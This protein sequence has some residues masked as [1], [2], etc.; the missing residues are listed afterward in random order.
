MSIGTSTIR[1]IILVAAVVIGLLMIGQAFGSSSTPTL[2][3]SSPS[4]SA[5]PSPSPSPSP[6][7]STKPPLTHAQAVNG[8]TVQVLNGS[9]VNG[10]G[11]SV[12]DT[13]KKKGYAICDTC[14]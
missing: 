3:A 8:V 6:S 4:P 10:L 9:G 1:G 12:A 2:V 13:L 5:S 14:V 11:A 7:Q